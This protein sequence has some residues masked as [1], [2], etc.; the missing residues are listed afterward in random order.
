VDTR[1]VDI[2]E[3]AEDKASVRMDMAADHLEAM[4]QE[5]ATAIFYH[6]SGLDAKKPM[7]LAPRFNSLAA[8]NGKQQPYKIFNRGL[9]NYLETQEGL[10]MYNCEK[11]GSKPFRENYKAMAH[12]IA[13][14]K[15]LSGSFVE[16]FE[17]ILAFGLSMEQAFR[18]A[19]KA[20][21]G[22]ADTSKPGAFTKDYLYWHGYHL[23]KKFI[24]SGGEIADLYIGKIS[25]N[26]VGEIRKMEKLQKPKYLPN[27]LK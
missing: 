22:M 21:R 14:N 4:A 10:A 3:K 1:M 12:V 6:N 27:W 20:K 8:E 11:V 5:G 17:K 23:I 24:E 25:L 16:V 18:S 15:A 19:L 9:A 2:Y 7:G 13:I 26:D